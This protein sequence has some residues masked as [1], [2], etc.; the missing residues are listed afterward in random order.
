[1]SVKLTQIHHLSTVL[2][3]SETRETRGCRFQNPEMS[4]IRLPD[5]SRA[6]RL[7]T[8]RELPGNALARL[9]IRCMT[10]NVP[11]GWYPDPATGQRRWWS[12][13]SWHEQPPLHGQKLFPDDRAYILNQALMEARRK[14][15]QMRVESQTQYQAVC[16]Y[17]QNPNHILHL[18]IAMFTCGL[19]LVVWCF[20]A[21]TSH[22]TRV[23]VTVD[24]YGNVSWV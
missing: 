23:T 16:V 20:I 18:L 12:G 19:W 9:T 21:L 10:T 11:A 17:G 5:S 13:S 15:P 8:F 1:M 14:A 4:Q 3:D 24:P 7:V 2:L 22:E 6:A